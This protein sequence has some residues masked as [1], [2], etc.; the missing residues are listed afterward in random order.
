MLTTDLPHPWDA[1]A[2]LQ[3]SRDPEDID[4]T[5]ARDDA[6]TNILEQLARTPGIAPDLIRRRFRNLG[7][8]RIAKFRHRRALHRS[9]YEA[10]TR[11]AGRYS[12]GNVAR[13]STLNAPDVVDL[14]AA[15]QAA[16]SIRSVLRPEDLNLLFE[17]GNGCSYDEAA[18]RRGV[19][20]ESLRIRIW[21]IRA[22][23][24][25]VADGFSDRRQ[26]DTRCRPLQQS[27]AAQLTRKI[28]D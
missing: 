17:L 10:N 2:E 28:L 1:Y 13:I 19:T 23:L 18:I 15:R 24:V 14:L 16:A 11:P 12:D 9:F 4:E 7:R 27:I 26:R 25:N 3:S 8:N 6:L 21:R 22:R 20:E 5:S